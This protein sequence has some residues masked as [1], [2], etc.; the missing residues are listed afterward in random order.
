MSQADGETGGGVIFGVAVGTGVGEGATEGLGDGL[1]SAAGF[2][3]NAVLE[4]TFA[5]L[6]AE[7]CATELTAE[8]TASP[9][10]GT[11]AIT[12]AEIALACDG[13]AEATAEAMAAA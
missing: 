11:A 13:T 4:I 3:V 1:S 6:L 10:P 7:D 5:G 8:E 2:C 12:A 9:W